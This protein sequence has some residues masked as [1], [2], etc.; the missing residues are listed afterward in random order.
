MPAGFW[1]ELWIRVG[2]TA[3]L[4]L[5]A[6]LFLQAGPWALALPV[7]VGVMVWL[8]WRVRG[9]DEDDDQEPPADA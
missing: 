9:D 2:M 7:F 3:I 1:R 4:A 5:I 6:M 8:K